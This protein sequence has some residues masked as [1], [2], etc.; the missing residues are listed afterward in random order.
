MSTTSKPQRPR[1]S[2]PHE[3]APHKYEILAEFRYLLMRYSAFSEQA[4]NEA[5]SAPHQPQALLAIK[6]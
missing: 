3:L 6:G 2:M 5:G 4:A 1:T